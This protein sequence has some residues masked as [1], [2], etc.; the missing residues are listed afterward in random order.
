MSNR[1]RNRMVSQPML[2][3]TVGDQS[4]TIMEF[5]IRITVMEVMFRGTFHGVYKPA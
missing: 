2:E 3:G 1:I 4:H 5:G